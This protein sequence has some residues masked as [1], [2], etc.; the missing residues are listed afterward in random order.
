MCRALGEYIESAGRR[1]KLSI[2]GKQ[3]LLKYLSRFT[4]S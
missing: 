3:A 1:N 4:L 2:A